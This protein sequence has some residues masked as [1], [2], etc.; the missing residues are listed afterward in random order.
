MAEMVLAPSR[1]DGKEANFIQKFGRA[2]VRGDAFTKL[3]LL[4]WG[5][6]YIGHGQL[7]KA[8]LVTLVQG[9]GLYFARKVAQSHGGVLV[10]SNLPAAHGA[11][12][13]LRLPICE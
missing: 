11:C 3:S 7:I 6:G 10:L 1:G 9:L 12:A 4:V 8:L 5:L 13:E 2:F